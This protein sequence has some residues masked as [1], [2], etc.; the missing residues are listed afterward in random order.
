MTKE[1][2]EKYE[3]SWEITENY[4][5]AGIEYELEFISDIFNLPKPWK[6]WYPGVLD[7]SDY[8]TK[9]DALIWFNRYLPDI[10]KGLP[11]WFVEV[12]EEMEEEAKRDSIYTR[13]L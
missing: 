3:N 6:I 13:N 10:R 8:I 12:P 11:L 5:L 1:K 7:I 2:A 9:K 4:L